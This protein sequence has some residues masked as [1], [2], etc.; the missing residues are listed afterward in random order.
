VRLKISTPSLSQL[1]RKYGV[2]LT[3]L[4][5]FAACYTDRFHL[6]LFA[7]LEEPD[8]SKLRLHVMSTRNIYWSFKYNFPSLT[9]YY[10]KNCLSVF[11][12]RNFRRFGIYKVSCTTGF[13][14]AN[15]GREQT[16]TPLSL[17]T[18]DSIEYCI[19]RRKCVSF[20]VWGDV[21][22]VSQSVSQ[23]VLASSPP[24]DLR[25]N[26]DSIWILLCCLCWT[27][28]LTRGRICI[29]S[30]TVS[31]NYPSWSFFFCPPPILHVTH[32]MYI[33]IQY[34]ACGSLMVKVLG[35][36]PEGRGFESQWDEILNVLKLSG[37]TRPWGLLSL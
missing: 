25:P 11:I 22:T 6:S 37:R 15:I 12:F 32:F 35:Y 21:T 19:R 14:V 8:N 1:S 4:L 36:K 24:W 33:L 2:R 34:G 28:S 17:D 30:V 18:Y 31:N 7:W 20:E 29:L 5:T 27:P 3:A 10:L 26:I 13:T 16:F 23:Y 9:K